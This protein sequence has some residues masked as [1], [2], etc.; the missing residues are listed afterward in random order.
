MNEA[1]QVAQRFYDYFAAGDF[2]SA[3]LLFDDDC[4]T[5][6]PMGSMDLA[7][8][9]AMVRAFKNGLPD[10]RMEVVRV[11]EEGDEAYISARFTGTHSGDL[12][13]PGGTLPASG[14]TLD[15]PFV[16]YW[17]VEA[18]KV[19]AHEVVWDQLGMMAQLGAAQSH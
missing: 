9:E 4:I 11:V 15:M 7:E 8:H 1:Q 13:T 5:V 10:A 17:R 3:K 14:K 16:D 2:S 6:L 19:V 12:V 18:G